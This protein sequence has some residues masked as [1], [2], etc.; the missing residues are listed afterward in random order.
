MTPV[1]RRRAIGESSRTRRSCRELDQPAETD[2]S[3]NHRPYIVLSL[4]CDP[5]VMLVFHWLQPTPTYCLLSLAMFYTHALLILNWSQLI[6]SRCL[7]SGNHFDLIYSRK[8]LSTTSTVFIASQI[9]ILLTVRVFFTNPCVQNFFLFR[10]VSLFTLHG[11]LVGW[12]CTKRQLNPCRRYESNYPPFSPSV[13]KN[14]GR[15]GSSIL[16]W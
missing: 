6:S 14:L 3:Q 10:G 7:F 12:D 2:F 9:D 1:W 4:P 15:L 16:I 13:R 5:N 8:W 11:R